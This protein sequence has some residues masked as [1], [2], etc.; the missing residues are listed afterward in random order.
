VLGEVLVDQ[1]GERR[2]AVDLLLAPDAF[3][4][5][6]YCVRRVTGTRESASL[7]AFGVAAAEPV[8]ARLEPLAVA[9]WALKLKHLTVLFHRPS[10]SVR[11]NL[12]CR[13]RKKNR[14]FA[15]DHDWRPPSSTSNSPVTRSTVLPAE[16]AYV[17]LVASGAE[18]LGK[19][20]PPCAALVEF[21]VGE[22][23]DVTRKLR[24]GAIKSRDARPA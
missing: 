6:F 18:L 1:F 14:S 9:S 20:M 8:A 24:P 12:S 11:I 4:R 13:E 5:T 3:E 10:F 19:S 23:M 16:L 22:A 17:D 21:D 7:D 15:G 2:R